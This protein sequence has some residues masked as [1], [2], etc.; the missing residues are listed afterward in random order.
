MYRIVIN[1]HTLD[2]F[3][4]ESVRAR[5]AA[6]TK[7]S[8]ETAGR[9][10]SGKS[11]VVK[12]G[13][14]QAT[15]V[16]YVEALREI[17]VDCS[18]E[19]ESLEIDLPAALAAVEPVAAPVTPTQ[20]RK[21]RAPNEKYCIEC[22]VPINGKAE[23]CPNCGVR[24]HS[25]PVSPQAHTAPSNARKWSPGVAAV[26][27]FFVPGLGQMYKGRIGAGLM[28]LIVVLIGYWLFI[29]PGLILHLVCLFNAA[30]GDPSK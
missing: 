8:E 22:G 4:R 25:A 6:L 17:G 3:D 26:L 1:G 15:G 30:S 2:G 24:Q 27:S 16:H 7:S 13:V 10:L 20:A 9:L 29:A 14:S 23:I 21:E 28:W 12:R 5:F 11:S 18:V 19:P